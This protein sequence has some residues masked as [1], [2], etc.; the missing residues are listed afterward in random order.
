[1]DRHSGSGCLA[2]PV[3]RLFSSEAYCGDGIPPGRGAPERAQRG[4][5]VGHREA[6]SGA[7]Y[8]GDLAG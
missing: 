8:G 5:A 4:S 6:A 2:N 7:G 3:K 1:M